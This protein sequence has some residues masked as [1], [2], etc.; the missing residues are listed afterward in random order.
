MV[1]QALP[2]GALAPQRVPFGVLGSLRRLVPRDDV[3]VAL[4]RALLAAQRDVQRLA[5]L[6]LQGHVG[7]LLAIL[8]VCAAL[9]VRPML[10]GALGCPFCIVSVQ[11]PETQEADMPH[12]CRTA[13]CKLF[14]SGASEQR[15]LLLLINRAMGSYGQRTCPFFV[16]CPMQKKGLPPGSPAGP[17]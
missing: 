15:M 12:G 1:A 17:T 2:R 5:L 7:Q 16:S 13:A 9:L 8:L 14:A 4:L 11:Q 3:V 10:V 6:A